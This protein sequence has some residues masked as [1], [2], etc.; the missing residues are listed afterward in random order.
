M[1]LSI[2][3]INRTSRYYREM[4]IERQGSIDRTFRIY[5]S[6]MLSSNNNNFQK[7]DHFVALG[8]YFTY[9]RLT[10]ENFVSPVWI[11]NFE[12]FIRNWHFENVSLSLGNRMK[13]KTHG[14]FCLQGVGKSETSKKKK[15]KFWKLVESGK[16]GN[17]SFAHFISKLQY[18]SCGHA[19]RKRPWRWSSSACAGDLRTVRA[20][21]L[22]AGNQHR[23]QGLFCRPTAASGLERSSANVRQRESAARIVLYT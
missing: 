2:Y 17:E 18:P 22:I 4:Y 23:V 11:F 7:N 8:T 16:K 10:Y 19:P 13:Y 14:W 6:L 1:Y 12:K 20:F 21:R 15:K 3:C 5:R 9:K